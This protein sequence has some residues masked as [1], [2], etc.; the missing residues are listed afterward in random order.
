LD[1]GTD[2]LNNVLRGG[3]L[4]DAQ[5]QLAYS[6]TAVVDTFSPRMRAIPKLTTPNRVHHVGSKQGVTAMLRKAAVD[7]STE[8]LLTEML[9]LLGDANDSLQ[10]IADVEQGIHEAKADGESVSGVSNDVISLMGQV[11]SLTTL[12]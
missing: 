11:S 2:K 4:Q 6:D 10:K 7:Y 5:R 8:G 9:G 12:K 3:N 1:P